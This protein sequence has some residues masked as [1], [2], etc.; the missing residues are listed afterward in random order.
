MGLEF[1]SMMEVDRTQPHAELDGVDID[2]RLTRYR[3][4]A[5]VNFITTKHPLADE[6][7]YYTVNNAQTGLA[8]AAAPT[9][10]SATN[11][12]LTIYNNASP[13]DD[14]AKRI[15]F[16]YMTFVATAPG[17]GGTNL[18]FAIVADRGNRYSSGGTLLSTI[19]INQSV[20]LNSGAKINAGNVTATAATA[21]ARTLVGNRY[22]KGAIPVIGD[23]Y[24]I[25]F[26]NTDVTDQ[27]VTSTITFS[28]NNVGP[29]V[30]G[31]DETLL[32]YFWLPS[33]SAASSYVPEIGYWER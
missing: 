25:R 8:T 28:S 3:E 17:T 13:S 18:Q 19:G 31:P 33:Q 21:S 20:S 9:A 23:Q 10:F 4:Q 1:N 16:D 30:I 12:F 26:G 11:P 14:F 15:Y 2:A 7:S 29:I 5:V 22:M 6:G 24:T 27:L 32:V